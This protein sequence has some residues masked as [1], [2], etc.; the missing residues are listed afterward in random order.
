[1][2]VVMQSASKSRPRKRQ[3]VVLVKFWYVRI[4]HAPTLKQSIV[5]TYVSAAK[6][7]LI[8]TFPSPSG[9]LGGF[10]TTL[11]ASVDNSLQISKIVHIGLMFMSINDDEK[12]SS[13]PLRS[14]PQCWWPTLLM[15]NN[16]KSTRCGT[17]GS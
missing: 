1:M 13:V 8:A 10:P 11:S 7:C 14:V 3:N 6:L 15:P 9:I 2:A 5:P 17:S 4:V 12:M 16:L